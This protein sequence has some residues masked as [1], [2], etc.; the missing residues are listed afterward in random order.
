M[1]IFTLF[2]FYLWLIFNVLHTVCDLE[3]FAH[4]KPYQLKLMRYHIHKISIFG[5]AKKYP[6]PMLP[7]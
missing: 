5:E 4:D 1:N 6:I 7:S 3:P 2:T